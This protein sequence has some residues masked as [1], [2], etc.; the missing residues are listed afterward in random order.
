MKTLKLMDEFGEARLLRREEQKL[1]PFSSP[2]YSPAIS[3]F[4]FASKY[5]V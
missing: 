4:C 2:F 3:H 5:Q 1:P